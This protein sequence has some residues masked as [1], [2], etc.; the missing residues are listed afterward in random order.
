[1]SV[2]NLQRDDIDASVA[3]ALSLSA[4]LHRI[5]VGRDHDVVDRKP[6]RIRIV[7]LITGSADNLHTTDTDVRIAI[8]A[9]AGNEVA[10]VE[11]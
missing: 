8:V 6:V 11:C 2:R 7:R 5:T 1:M 9:D 3:V 4:E 10:D